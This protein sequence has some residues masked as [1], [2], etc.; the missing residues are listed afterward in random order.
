MFVSR[1]PRAVNCQRS[2]RL[3]SR[4]L[5]M[6]SVGILLAILG[7]A[8][9]LEVTSFQ[10]HNEFH[11]PS[12]NGADAE[13]PPWIVHAGP[14]KNF[15]LV[16]HE[17]T[18]YCTDPDTLI[19]VDAPYERPVSFSGDSNCRRK[20]H[21]AQVE[22]PNARGPLLGGRDP[23]F[24]QLYPKER[25]RP[26]WIH[27]RNYEGA[28]SGQI[29][30]D[31]AN[32]R[33]V[34]FNHAEN[35]NRKY[36]SRG[37]FQNSLT[38]VKRQE[39][40]EDWRTGETCW[41]S[42]AAFVSTSEIP[43]TGQTNWG[44]KGKWESRGPVVWPR[45][46]YRRW[47]VQAGWVKTNDWPGLSGV[48]HPTSFVH[49]GFVYLYY[50][51]EGVGVMVARSP[52]SE[53]G[54]PGTFHVWRRGHGFTEPALPAGFDVDRIDDFFHL[55]GPSNGTVILEPGVNRF[56]VA[57]LANSPLFLGVETHYSG[58]GEGM[59]VSLRYSIDLVNW[60]ERK[61]VLESSSIQTFPALFS[62]PLNKTGETHNEVDL[63]DF[64]IVGVNFETRDVTTIHVSAKI[65]P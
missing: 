15:Y 46:G 32:A 19:D 26:T 27:R 35:V 44:R 57:K 4:R 52:L 28:Y 9:E 29:I 49:D 42:Y 53:Y 36:G 24:A 21:G 25:Y 51:E 37:T 54:R 13:V 14:T 5:Q 55:P 11:T 45:N 17:Q 34:T 38:H 2:V 16:S 30:G 65:S 43:F 10:W 59:A 60:S 61:T 31:G 20:T 41:P 47:D 39:C 7:T 33:L 62:V 64:Y 23:F 48:Y 18:N 50:I 58:Q 12:R 40:I 8:C 56:A 22:F 1:I 3:N 63:D 6:L